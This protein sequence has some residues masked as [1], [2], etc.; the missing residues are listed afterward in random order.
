M[1][2][3]LIAND[4]VAGA[5]NIMDPK[6]SQQLFCAMTVSEDNDTSVQPQTSQWG[7]LRKICGEG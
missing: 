4:T 6:G 1:G 7:R 5:N 3:A 2:G